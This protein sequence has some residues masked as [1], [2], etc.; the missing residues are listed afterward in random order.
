M[1]KWGLVRTSIYIQNSFTCETSSQGSNYIQDSFTCETSSQGSTSIQDSFTCET[2]SQ[3]SKKSYVV[4][5][6]ARERVS[7]SLI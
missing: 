2:S 1:E 4:Q 3:G 7:Y 5:R 6:A